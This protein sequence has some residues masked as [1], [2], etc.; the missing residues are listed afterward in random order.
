VGAIFD[1]RGAGYCV[2]GTHKGRRYKTLSAAGTHGHG[3]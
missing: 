3:L 2:N 1:K